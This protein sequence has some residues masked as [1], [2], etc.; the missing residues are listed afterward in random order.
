MADAKIT[1]LIENTTPIT[2]DLFAIVDDPA[3]APA[4]QKI[5]INN[6]GILTGWVTA[7]ETWTYASANT[8]TVPS[9]A[10][11]KYAVGD[12][13]KWTQTT[14]K[15]GV[16]TAV[17]DTV[18]TI[19]VN[20]DYTVA[21][22]AI[23]LNYYSHEENPIGYPHWFTISAPTFTVAT[24]DNASGG[25]PTT[26]VLRA[27]IDGQT[28]TVYIHGDGTKAGAGAFY[29]LGM[30]NMPTLN[31]PFGSAGRC[32]IGTAHSFVGSAETVFAVFYYTVDGLLYVVQDVS[33]A[34]NATMADINILISYE[35]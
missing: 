21:N 2:G 31:S 30:Q 20:T 13:I 6:L 32:M 8:I 22:A 14:V 35:I 23:T 17:A 26:D 4:T 1:A 11:S 27:K 18:L 16:I 28:A 9:G 25:Q 12:R 5:D 19:M 34:D 24:I 7:G 3:G 33:I 29:T 15:Y 10:A